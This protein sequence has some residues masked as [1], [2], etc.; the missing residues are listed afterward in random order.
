MKRM[1]LLLAVA[2]MMA[3]MMVGAGPASADAGAP[4]SCMGHEASNLSP[5]GSS[6]EL[7]GGMP[8]FEAFFRD[9]FP[10]TPPGALKKTIAKLHEGSH[11]ACDQAI[12]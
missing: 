1:L 11:E 3:S 7:A 2:V 8:A 10:G 4:A 6:D 12:G 5:P 9:T